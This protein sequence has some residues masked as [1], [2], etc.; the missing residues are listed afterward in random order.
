MKT[1]GE[2]LKAARLTR[3]LSLKKAALVTKIQ[4]RFLEALEQ[5]QFQELPSLAS[6]RGFL[7]NYAEFLDLSS[8]SVLALFRRD[9]RD[10]KVVKSKKTFQF[11]WR[12]K[13][14]MI[15]VFAF[16]FLSL[17]GYLAYQYFSLSKP[18]FLEINSPLPDAK[19]KSD[20][21]EILGQADPDALVTVN[22]QPVFLTG[23]GEFRYKLELF[24]GENKIIVEAK[25]RLGRTSQI[26]RTIF[27]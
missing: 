7:K 20:K 18:P 22:N 8:A 13:I 12:P 5:N 1:A 3:G 21:V 10:E 19:I 23:E 11:N 15:G 25:S 6:A 14:L 17:S 26:E 24:S 16:F 9:F 4:P 2:V 27:H